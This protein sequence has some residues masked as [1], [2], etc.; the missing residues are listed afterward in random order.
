VHFINVDDGVWAIISW[1]EFCHAIIALQFVFVAT[2]E[3]GQMDA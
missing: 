2:M 3:F 1:H